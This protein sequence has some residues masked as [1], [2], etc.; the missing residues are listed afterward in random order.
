MLASRVGRCAI[1]AMRHNII[2]R[3]G[4]CASLGCSPVCGPFWPLLAYMDAGLFGLY[5]WQLEQY[6]RDGWQV[7][8]QAMID[9]FT[10]QTQLSFPLD[11]RRVTNH[12]AI[13]TAVYSSHT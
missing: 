7:E 4:L 1:A 8:L 9:G 10:R 2:F 3:P 6:G 12:R 5:R 13:T 11:R